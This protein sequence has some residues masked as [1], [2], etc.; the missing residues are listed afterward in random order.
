[1]ALEN[2]NS[3]TAVHGGSIARKQAF[4][5]VTTPLVCSSTYAFEDTAEIRRYFDGD[6]E[7]EEYGRYGNPTVRAA[8]ER[9]AALEGAE[10]ALLFSSGMAA[11]TTTLLAM[12]K[13]GDHVVMT[14]DCYR[15]T[16]QFVNQVLSRF[17]VEATSVEPGDYDAL[18]IAIRPGRTRLLL[19]ESPTNPY[20]RLVD[21]PRL[22]RIRDAHKNLKLLI[23]STFATP[24]NQ[25]PLSLGADLVL[26]SA[27][28]Y[29][30]GHNDLLAGVVCGN[31]GI[32]AA[33]R[34]FRGV[35]GGVLDPHSAYLLIRGLK[36]LPLRVSRQNETGLRVAQWLEKHPKVERVFYPGLESHP[37]HA[38]ARA[39]MKGFGGVVSF[40][41]KGDLDVAAR[42][43]DG[44]R[45]AS[46]APSFGGVETL[47]EQPALMSFYE[48]T[49]EQRLAVGIRDNLIRLSVG[50]EEP[51]DL[52]ADLSNAL[53]QV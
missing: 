37:D 31:A 23:D 34:D 46:V 30:G 49:T 13:A 40:L 21:L 11:V 36:T 27:T 10:D 42:F 45:L 9:L 39:Q 41:V 26:H 50:I 20:L 38:L 7:R 47:V 35:L 22:S 15:R 19:S 5:A 14:S 3:T 25:R 53:E 44:C 32:I 18:A 28:K 48:L 8:E 29:L 51:E 17:G 33:L 52:L 4:D 2:P 6:Q 43:I 12:L 1:M 24:C 16:R